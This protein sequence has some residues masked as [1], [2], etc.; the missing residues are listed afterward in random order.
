MTGSEAD[1]EE[2]PRDAMSRGAA[3]Y[4]GLGE[5]RIK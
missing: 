3:G 4:E 5:S 1:D 2:T